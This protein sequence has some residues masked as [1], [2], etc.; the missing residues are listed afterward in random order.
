MKKILSL[1]I[2]AI[3]ALT[4]YSC[5]KEEV[6]G[7]NEIVFSL[8]G[9]HFTDATKTSFDTPSATAIP[10]QWSAGDKIY[11]ASILSNAISSDCATAEFTFGTT[12]S[13]EGNLDIFY[14]MTGTSASQANVLAAQ[15]MS[16][17]LN[18]GSNGDFGYASTSDYST[19]T[20]QHYTTY[21]WLNPYSTT[22]TSKITSIAITAEKNIVGKATFN[23]GTKVFGD[24]SD[25]SKTITL[26][27]TGGLTM[28]T[29]SSDNSVLAA[30]VILPIDLSGTTL[31][32]TY[33]FAD[34]SFFSS[35][36]AITAAFASGN[37]Y[38]ISD[39]VASTYTI[40]T[41]TFE[42]ADYKGDVNF[43]GETNWSSLID[44]PQ[45]GGTLLYGD[46]GSG[47]SDY[48]WIDGGNTELA[49]EFP[50]NWGTTCYWGGGHAISN[51]V[52]MDLAKGTYE[53]Q[54]SVYYKDAKTEKGGHNGS[55]NFCVHYGYHDYSGYS[56]ENLPYFYFSDGA[57]RIV[58][59]MYVMNT[60]YAMNCY[61]DGNSLTAKIGDG[62]WV[63]LIAIGYDSKSNE[64]GR[65]EFYMVNGPDNIVST[66]T[67]WDLS[68]LGKVLKIDFNIAGSSDNGYGFSQPAYFA[69]DDVA[70]RFEN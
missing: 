18:L 39:D 55:D 31:N 19:F 2:I 13:G 15:T 59:H 4:I 36:R 62:D 50:T 56:A 53:Y 51:Y 46:S 11:A 9:T 21:L 57:E 65:C 32:V 17:S 1:A 10:F 47:P 67:K 25:G 16:T 5:Q 33:T 8:I 7:N 24:I 44:N 22:V 58:D 34:G 40:K 20:L 29:T 41:L 3:A 37:T 64:T 45:Y 12:P 30:A 14:N 48:Y 63:K 26:T 49:S 6:I 52:E 42:D 68:S 27:I 43:A 35:T 61:I 66:W 54:L 70:V 38:R 69:Y 60:T 28:P 23:T